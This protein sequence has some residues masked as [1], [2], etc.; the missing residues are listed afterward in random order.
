MTEDASEVRAA[1]AQGKVAIY[2][3]DNG[4]D[5]ATNLTFRTSRGAFGPPLVGSVLRGPGWLGRGVVMQEEFA[6][7]C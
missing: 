1:V 6:C 3:V 7:C 5:A 2:D 4:W